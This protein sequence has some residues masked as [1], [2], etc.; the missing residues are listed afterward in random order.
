MNKRSKDVHNLCIKYKVPN[1]FKQK[2]TKAS[3]RPNVMLD[4]E[5]DH[6]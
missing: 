1:N 4:N 2:V 6:I 5:V 3:R